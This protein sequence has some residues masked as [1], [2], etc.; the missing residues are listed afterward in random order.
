MFSA[1]LYTFPKRLV[2][3]PHTVPLL[4]QGQSI[5]NNVAERKKSSI[6]VAAQKVGWRRNGRNMEAETIT[7]NLWVAKT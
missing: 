4:L 1:V 7:L 2:D 5:P 6:R 3:E